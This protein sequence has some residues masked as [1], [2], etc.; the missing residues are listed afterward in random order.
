MFYCN[1]FYI[2]KRLNIK[3]ETFAS[4]YYII[5]LLDTRAQIIFLSEIQ[6][7]IGSRS[8]K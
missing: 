7:H 4:M 1:L 8:Q 3:V 5:F 2:E 6:H